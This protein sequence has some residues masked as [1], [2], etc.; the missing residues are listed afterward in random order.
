[1]ESACPDLAPSRDKVGIQNSTY[2]TSTQ[3][4]RH[5][6]DCSA[7]IEYRGGTERPSSLEEEGSRGWS[8]V[9][10]DSSKYVPNEHPWIQYSPL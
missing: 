2:G 7:D 6:A 10:I 1:M 5:T 4:H 8:I 3:L 9:G